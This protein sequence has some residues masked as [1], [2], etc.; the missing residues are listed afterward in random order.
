MGDKFSPPADINTVKLELVRIKLI[1]EDHNKF[2]FAKRKKNMDTLARLGI[3]PA[4][5][6]SYINELTYKNYLS[7]PSDDRDTGDKACVW[8]FGMTIQEMDVYIKI[9]HIPIDDLLAISFHEKE[10][11][12]V[13]RY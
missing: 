7:G 11:E 6:I 12:F 8:E 1:L 2:H 10:K 5:C 3:T 13:F 9:K 4:G